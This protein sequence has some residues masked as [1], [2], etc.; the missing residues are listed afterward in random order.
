M[1]ETTTV[2]VHVTTRARLNQ[3]GA[4]SRRTVDEVILASLAALERE[5]WQQL[6][7]RAAE[8]AAALAGDEA[9]LAESLAIQ[10]DLAE[11]RAW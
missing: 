8:Q 6:K 7:A 3:I 2:K 1:A 4:Q 9:E 10:A 11:H 5:Q